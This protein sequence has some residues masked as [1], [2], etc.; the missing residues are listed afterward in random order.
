MRASTQA[1]KSSLVVVG[2]GMVGHRLLER[3]VDQGLTRKFDVTLFG[4]EPRPAYDRVALSSLFDG[5]SPEDLSLVPSGF[6]QQTG[7]RSHIGDRVV[8]LDRANKTVRTERGA[9]IRYDK[10]VL[11]TG[12]RPFV[13][14]LAGCDLAGCFVYRTVEDVGAIREWAVGA[15]VAPSSEEDCSGSRLPGPSPRSA[16]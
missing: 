3:I 4:E 14:P 2:H 13:P 5:L 9:S 6:F 8:D 7:I 10:L 16:S 15:R 1:N 12:S 11:A